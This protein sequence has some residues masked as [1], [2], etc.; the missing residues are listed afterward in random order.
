MHDDKDLLQPAPQRRADDLAVDA[1]HL[2]RVHEAIFLQHMLDGARTASSPTVERH[3]DLEHAVLILPS[4]DDER[5]GYQFTAA[6]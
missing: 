2:W 6:G 3:I 4:E 1:V 5:I